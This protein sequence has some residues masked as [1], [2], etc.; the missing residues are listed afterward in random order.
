MGRRQRQDSGQWAVGEAADDACSSRH[1]RQRRTYIYTFLM[2][3]LIS[4]MA[5][6]RLGWGPI[7]GL[8]AEDK[9]EGEI[10]PR[11]DGHVGAL[12]AFPPPSITASV[13]RP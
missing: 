9:L 12:P 5:A 13:H 6:R 3:L 11:H 2:P 8:G 1:F 4:S 7:V 10:K